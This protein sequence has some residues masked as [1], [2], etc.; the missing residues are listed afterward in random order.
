MLI[1][2]F[3]EQKLNNLGLCET[4]W[5]KQGVFNRGEYTIVHSGSEKGGNKGVAVILDKHHGNCL[6]I[7]NNINDRIMMIKLNTK[8]APSV[9]SNLPEH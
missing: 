1:E 3:K 6:K 7:Y 8:P 9:R 5:S 4:R 2:E